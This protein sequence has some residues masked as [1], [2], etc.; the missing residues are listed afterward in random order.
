MRL[1][2]IDYGAGNVFSVKSA[3]ERLG[4]QP[5]L[6]A[7]EEEI[8]SS[9][10][11]VFPGVGHAQ[12]AMTQLKAT[13]LDKVIPTLKQPVLGVC[14]GMQLMCDATE[15]GDTTGLGI[16]NGVNVIRFDD[17][18]K[19]PHMGWNELENSKGTLT[20]INEA[21]YFVHSYYAPLSDYT[22]AECLYPFAFSAALEKDNFMACQFHP[23]KSG[24]VGE[25]VLKRFINKGI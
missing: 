15:E 16:F 1:T 23:E 25:E 11:V 8:R 5:V 12:S 13:G 6:S 17:Q 22:I 3:F 24:K 14:L 10:L 21:V 7:H 20:G 4:L 9:D 2:I 18:L 19:V